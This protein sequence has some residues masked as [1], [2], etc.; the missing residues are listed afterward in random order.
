MRVFRV[1]PL[2]LGVCLTAVGCSALAAD[3]YADDVRRAELVGRWRAAS[4]DAELRLDADG[5]A[6]VTRLPTSMEYGEVLR[7]RSG[8]GTW[9]I[10][11]LGEDPKLDV[12]VKHAGE[13]LD[14][15]RHDGRLVVQ[16]FVG[17]PDNGDDCR[18]T[19]QRS[20]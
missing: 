18:F 1:V 8:S 12:R 19:R 11:R 4:C 3:P 17:D 2:L 20:R 5:S 13:S 10:G 7:S 6:R 16:M 9:D 15:L 14:L